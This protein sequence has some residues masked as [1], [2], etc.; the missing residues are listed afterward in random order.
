MTMT[1]L[2]TRK[3]RA[4]LPI[5]TILP[6]A[7]LLVAL[8]MFAMELVQFA[9]SR[10][11]LQTDITVAGVPVTGLTQSQ[12]VTTWES[13][14]FQPIQL[15]YLN[16]PM[17]LLPAD[18]G[19]RINSQQMQ[20][21]IRSQLSSG[22][23]YWG[24]FWNYLWRRPSSP[25]DIPLI[26]DFSEARLRTFMED[27]AAR[28][29]QR[30]GQAGFDFNT[31]TF[32]N[33]S[34]GMKVDVRKSMDAIEAALMRPTNRTVRLVMETQGGRAADM[35]TLKQALLAY[36]DKKGFNPNGP[37]TLASVGVIDLQTGQEMWI[38][39]DIAYSSMSTMKIPVMLNFFSLQ[40]FAIEAQDKWM[41]AGSMLCSHNV[42][43]NFLI[44]LAGQGNTADAKMADG[45][46]R[47][48]DTATKLGAKYTFINAPFWV[49]AKAFSI[50]DNPPPVPDPKFD[51]RPDTW[52][53]TIP[54]DMAT[55]LQGIYDCAQ[56]GSGIAAI[57]PDSFN[58]KKCK[59]MIELMS[60]NK[61]DRLIELGVPEGTRVAHKNGWGG[62]QTHGANVSDAGIV[63]TPGGDYVLVAFMWEAKANPD[64][65][66]LSMIGWESI[67]G[68]SQV[69]YNFFNPATPMTMARTPINPNGAI[70]CVMPSSAEKV[71]FT[72]INS[73]RFDQKGNVEPDACYFWPTC[74]EYPVPD[75]LKNRN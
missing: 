60:G 34:N 37:D 23:T 39:P 47:V 31:L 24:D 15:Q 3:R 71:D 59:E 49:G 1:G 74:N 26:A 30:A 45:L 70:G 41:L 7:M 68:V 69:V 6:S 56:Y 66:P 13:V 17:L 22:G 20:E 27:V 9:Q 5:L 8:V 54:E 62:T 75:A 16:S 2:G 50:N 44:Q 48:G 4:R 18:V 65:L 14:Y 61:I 63:F 57:M 73:G 28:Y 11:R 67:E 42:Y 55:L 38:N 53:R 51:A 32:N 25:I 19:F 52:S 35:D 12:A 36:L 29:D 58:Q 46:K 40:Q 43:S 72:N 33:G 10:D 21:Q 64:G